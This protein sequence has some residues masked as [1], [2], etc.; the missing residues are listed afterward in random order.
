MPGRWRELG[1]A[2][3]KASLGTGRILRRRD[4]TGEPAILAEGFRAVEW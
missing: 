4:G 2:I 1:R 3:K